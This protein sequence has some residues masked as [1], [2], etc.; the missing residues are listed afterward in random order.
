MCLFCA[1]GNLP[2][3]RTSA[4]ARR[5]SRPVLLS[6]LRRHRFLFHLRSLVGYDEPEILGFAKSPKLSPNYC[7]RILDHKAGMSSP[8][9]FMVGTA[10]RR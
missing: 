2:D 1:A 6:R 3:R 10:H 4:L 5:I 7:R 9:G 8:N